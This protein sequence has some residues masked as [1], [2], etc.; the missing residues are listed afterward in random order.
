MGEDHEHDFNEA[1][2]K[3]SLGRSPLDKTLRRWVSCGEGKIFAVRLNWITW[4]MAVAITWGFAIGTLANS[5][6]S[7]KY[8]SQ[9]KT[10][11]TQNFTWL[12]IITQDI[13]CVFLIYL[14]FS[15]FGSIKLGRDDEKPRYNDFTWFAM[16]FT[17]GVAVGLYV[18]GVAEPL[19]FY[20]Q[21]V[22]WFGY[23]GSYDYN[24]YKVNT[25]TDAMRAQQAI[26][27]AVYHW[28]IH[29]WVPY[30][31][32]ALLVGVVSFRWGLPMT[33]RS[34][35]Y[36][37]LGDHAL[38]LFGDLIDSI[39]I[40]TTTFGVCTSLGLGVSQLSSGLQYVKRIGCS[41]MDKCAEAGGIWDVNTYGAD[42]CYTPG[43]EVQAYDECTA[44]WLQNGEA[45]RGSQY[46]IIGLITFFATISVLTGID[47]GIK[48][49]AK[50]AFTLGM[51]VMV[52]VLLG[53]NTWY[54]LNVMVQTTGYYLNHVVQV[55]F[56]CEAFQQLGIEFSAFGATN[57]LWGSAGSDSTVNKL[58]AHDVSITMTSSDCG[59]QANPCSAGMI[60]SAI[61]TAIA[62]GG[63]LAAQNI[64]YL[65]SI[66][67]SPTSIQNLQDVNAAL[68][69]VY[70][71]AVST[72][73]GG[74][75]TY[76]ADTGVTSHGAAS[77]LAITGS[78]ASTG[79]DV[80][81]GLA[82]AA[83]T[84]CQTAW[85]GD[86]P[87]CP[88]TLTSNAGDWGVCSSYAMS[89]PIT[90]TY[91]DDSNPSFMDWWTIFYWAWWITWAP[92]V[93]FFVAIISRGRTVREVIVG[94]FVCPTI[95]AIIW[96]SVFGGLAIKMERTAE[97]AL[98]VRADHHHAAVQCSEH[99]SGGNPITPES[100]KLAAAGYYML[101]CMPP[102]DQI[103]LLMEPY[104]N[105]QG[106]LHFALWLG[107]VIYFLTSSDSGSMTDDIISAS[108]LSA[109]YI[110]SW[111][112]VFWCFT[113][114][115][116][117]MALLKEGNSLSSLRALSI[118]IGLPYTIF[119]CMM[120]PACYR[121]LKKEAG[122]EDIASSKRFNT[123]LL[124]FLEGFKPNGGSPCAPVEHLKHV[125][126]GLFVP[127]LPIYNIYTKLWP[128]D[129]LGAILYGAG[130]MG[131]YLVWFILHIVEVEHKHSYLVAWLLF[132]F[133]L[134]IVVHLRVE[135]RL[136]YKVWGS[137]VDDIFVAL[138]MY[139]FVLAQC[140]MQVGNDG[141]G[142]PDYFASADEVIAEMAEASD[143]KF[144]KATSTNTKTDVEAPVSAA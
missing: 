107:L 43:G 97:M 100:K 127:G 133:F 96:F 139:P 50:C 99:Y 131:C 33:I 129:T 35:F 83:Y 122:D 141:A 137:P 69:G 109:G 25:Q 66:G 116:V 58:L 8:F 128:E 49:L 104:E 125:L 14:G 26:F 73:C 87:R 94:G 84:A 36:P 67:M 28:G 85:A 34:C 78:E 52:T 86:F 12:Y 121:A 95:F 13:W 118:V 61:T 2:V 123:Q 23:G 62:A 80:C 9:G 90:A 53:D 134:A 65:A 71:G 110:P 4:I 56:D 27:M 22:S 42:M 74:S 44:D 40:S 31:L 91:Y 108:G 111:Q 37:L 105:L 103:Y 39:S 114:G 142:S 64:N 7:S 77:S 120:V 20:R 76:D 21:P 126:T 16:L 24:H 132:F 143:E 30:I 136:K 3:A 5:E 113:E 112:K 59:D 101:T 54:L 19:Y 48:Y 106:F 47:R 10:W 98:S 115:I 15:R 117:A 81:A 38:G 6:E 79:A 11:V 130:S 88:E 57:Y 102:N 45:Q 72:P 63:V 46:L 29:G 1:Q 93:G 32:L 60:N 119:L 68:A 75:F 17:C 135:T 138:L 51:V 70:G 82:G 144:A 41:R 55:G 18:Y 92:F 124:D 140:A 89:C